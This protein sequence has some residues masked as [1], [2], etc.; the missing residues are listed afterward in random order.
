MVIFRVI[1]SQQRVGTILY[2][3]SPV[4]P[5]PHF[6]FSVSP[7]SISRLFIPFRT[8]S[9]SVFRNSFVCHSYENCR[10]CT[11]NSQNGKLRL[12]PERNSHDSRNL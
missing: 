9:F 12:A 11:N 8:L 4:L 3:Y 6:H 10:V 1:T 5:F 7:S 2:P